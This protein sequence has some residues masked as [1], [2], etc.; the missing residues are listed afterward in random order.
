MAHELRVVSPG[1]NFALGQRCR[2]INDALVRGP[3]ET[4]RDVVMR[5]HK[6]AIHQHIDS[7]QQAIGHFGMAQ[8]LGFCKSSTKSPV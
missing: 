3:S 5:L 6:R 4:Q 8:I 7:R 1:L 2:Q